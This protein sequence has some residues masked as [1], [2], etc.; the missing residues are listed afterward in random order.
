MALRT[1][2]QLSARSAAFE[3]RRPIFD[4]GNAL[5]LNVSDDSAT[6]PETPSEPHS[7]KSRDEAEEFLASSKP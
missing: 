5:N 3:S 1:T 2:T 6:C 4:I 7:F